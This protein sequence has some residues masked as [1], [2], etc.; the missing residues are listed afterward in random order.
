MAMKKTLTIGAVFWLGFSSMA[1]ATPMAGTAGSDVPA[2]HWAYGAV[3]QLAD[4]GL[5]VDGYD[6]TGEFQGDK[7]M[8]RY[9]MAQ[10]VAKVSLKKQQATPKDAALLKTLQTEYKDELAAHNERIKKLEHD[11]QRIQIHGDVALRYYNDKYSNIDTTKQTAETHG[12]NGTVPNGN[13]TLYMSIY[14]DYNINKDWTAHTQSELKYYWGDTLGTKGSIDLGDMQH[15]LWFDGK[16]GEFNITAGRKWDARGMGLVWATDPTGLWLNYGKSHATFFVGQGESNKGWNSETGANGSEHVDAYYLQAWK[17]I[18]PS[19]FANLVLGGN[20]RQANLDKTSPKTTLANKFA[21]LSADMKLNN[22]WRMQ[23]GYGRSNAED[24]NNAYGI[25]FKYKDID[26]NRPGSMSITFKGFHY[27]RNASFYSD[28]AYLGS[29]GGK[30]GTTGFNGY[31]DM[32]GALAVDNNQQAY[33]SYLKGWLVA[34]DYVLDKDVDM[35]I[36]Y[37]DQNLEQPGQASDVKRKLFRTVVNF[38]Y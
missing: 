11:T 8:T 3:K 35:E 29:W 9:E 32:W 22:D 30:Y 12:K 24:F 34:L 13:Q 25:G 31:D 4:D 2:G 14:T 15:R 28:G 19:S 7:I 1:M 20:Q 18:A 23:V 5:L 16:A 10:I 37:T 26:L 38:R 27:G 21:E 33:T 6:L 36:L 17:T